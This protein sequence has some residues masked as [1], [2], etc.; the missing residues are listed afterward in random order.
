MNVNELII[1][2]LSFLDVPVKYQEYKGTMINGKM[3]IVDT[4]ITFFELNN[5]DDDYS[6]DEAETEVHSIQIDLWSKKDM[7]QFKKDIKKA[8]KA[9]GFKGVTFQDLYEKETQIYHIAFRCYFYEE[10]EE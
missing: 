10:E 7:T 3:V 4:Y 1:S 6:E 2:T 9:A 8:L 5:I